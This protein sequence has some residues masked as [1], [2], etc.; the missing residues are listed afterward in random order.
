MDED[1]AISFDEMADYINMMILLNGDIESEEYQQA[2]SEL[3][4]TDKAVDRARILLQAELIA[5]EN[6]N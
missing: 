1:E 6:S 5:R 2:K 3:Q 4:T